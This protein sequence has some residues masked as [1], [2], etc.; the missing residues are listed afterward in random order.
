MDD[1]GDTLEPID[2]SE[3]AGFFNL[4]GLDV[5]DGS[6]ASESTGGGGE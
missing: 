2:P 5:S 3:L 6:D 4:D 1:F